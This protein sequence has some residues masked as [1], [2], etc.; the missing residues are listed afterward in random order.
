M[1]QPTVPDYII[2]DEMRRKRERAERDDRPRLEVPRYEPYWPP[3]DAD[4]DDSETREEKPSRGE[5]VI[6]MW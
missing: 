2:Y 1:T 3:A 6:R 5:T 4:A